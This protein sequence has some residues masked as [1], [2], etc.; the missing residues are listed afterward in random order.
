[1][2]SRL[3][4][5]HAADEISDTLATAKRTIG[6][7]DTTVQDL[8]KAIATLNSQQ[9][10]GQSALGDTIADLRS[11]TRAAA[12]AA[13]AA[14]IAVERLTPHA[15]DDLDAVRATLEQVQRT[16]RSLEELSREVKGRPSLLVRDLSQ[17]RRDIP[18]K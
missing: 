14:R 13:T 17:P 3:E 10:R 1:M 6:D 16:V 9:Q 8:N 18:D 2:T 11:T 12:D 15:E 5:R 4:E 7:I